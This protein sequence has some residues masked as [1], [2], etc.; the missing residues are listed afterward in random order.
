MRRFRALRNIGVV[1]GGALV[2]AALAVRAEGPLTMGGPGFI[3]GKPFRWDP[4]SFPL[5]YWTDQGALGNQTNTQADSLVAQAFQTWQAVP[6]ANITFS[7]E[8]K[9]G[10]D[11]TSANYMTFANNLGDCSTAPGPPA[12][13]IAQNRSVV[14]DDDGSI[15]TA[16]GWDPNSLLGF[17]EPVC[18]DSNGSENLYT[19]GLAL[20]NGKW[21]DGQ[22]DSPSNPEVSL[23]LFTGVFVHEFGHL[24]GLDH[25]QVNLNCLTSM[26]CPA[27][28]LQ[29]LPTMFPFID[30]FVGN[31]ELLSLSVDDVAAVSALYPETA[32]NP[33]NQV[34][35]S[36]TTGTIQGRVFFSDGTTQVQSLNIIA[37]RVDD[38]RR[39]ALS[40]VSGFLFTPD[41][42]NPVYP[43]LGSPFGSHDETLIGYYEIPGLS[44]GDYTIEVEAIDPDFTEG[45][46]VGPVAGYGVAF[47]MPGNCATEFANT[48]PPESDSDSCTDQTPVPVTAG[49]VIET[50]TDIILNG[51]PP[52]FDAWEDE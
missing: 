7:A 20:L 48:S 8:G 46:G 32:N 50:G 3:D 39:I 14:Y 47:P 36:S 40:S 45:S 35:F 44:A 31:N 16:L 13:G 37:R 2:L 21:I 33:P 49:A 24:I 51:T 11:I 26:S 43:W 30:P 29:G 15:I 28:D 23:S 42:G 27:A 25:S 41:A 12:G 22:P 34:P 4:A 1:C 5:T 19:R 6:T 18:F 38:P 9:L 10:A 52:R 17:A